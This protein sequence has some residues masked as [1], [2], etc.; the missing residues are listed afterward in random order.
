MQA[1]LIPG[2]LNEQ[3]GDAGRWAFLKQRL[4]NEG[5]LS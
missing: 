3:K 2:L 4:R 5:D 1:F